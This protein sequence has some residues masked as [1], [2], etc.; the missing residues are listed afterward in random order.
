MTQMTPAAAMRATPRRVRRTYALSDLAVAPE[1][2]RAAEPADDEIPHLAETIAAAGLLQLLT[3]RPGRGRRERPGMVLDGRRRLLALSLLLEAGRITGDYPVEAFVETDRG[4]QAAA[5]ILTNTAAPVHVA[6]VILAIGKMLK[7][8]LTPAAIAAALGYAEVEVRRL[9]ALSELP[10]VAFDAL[11]KGRINLRQARL[12]ARLPDREQRAEIAQAALD[13]AGFQ[14]WRIS[15]EL[16]AGRITDR[17]PRFV[18]VGVARYAGQGGRTEADLFG[19]RPAVLLDPAALQTSWKAR[20]AELA[21]GLAAEGRAVQVCHGDASGPEGLQPFGYACGLGLD[22]P[23]LEAWRLAEQAARD[24][25]AH[26]A[27]LDLAAAEADAGIARFLAARLAAQQAAEPGRAVSLVR[28]TPDRN[29]GL[30]LR[31]WGPPLAGGEAAAEGERPDD[32]DGDP[33]DAGEGVVI[34]LPTSPEPPA[35]PLARAPAPELDGVGHALHEVRTDVATRAL[36]RALADD[37]AAALVAVVA[38]LFNV[39]V[40]RRGL[41]RRGGA[42]TLHA[43]AY[44]RPRSVPIEALDG[45]VRRRLADRRAAWAG[46]GLSPIA[47]VAGLADGDRLALLAEMAGLSLDLREDRT[48]E[49]RRNARAEAVE[50]AA[51]CAADVTRHWTP[52]AAYLGA[53]SKAQLLAMLEVMGRP[54]AGAGALRKDELVG[55]AATAAAERRWAPP[56]LSWSAAPEA[57]E[58]ASEAAGDDPEAHG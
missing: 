40:L 30:D 58:P 34:R 26:L 20:A 53:H 2:L 3:V 24:A 17:D 47:W 15:D 49:V 54:A 51:L 56:F 25:G 48:T 50:L 5:A 45:D 11:R 36:V 18:L 33:H 44:S 52:D 7:A 23:G 41:G 22:T 28:V 14:E 46:S 37:P 42:L 9:A 1:N 29:T 31:A 27:D 21:A 57:A 8:R 10:A 19:E 16:D 6:D 4:R 39:V 13:G 38:R 55:L 12:L 32:A 43:E 35:A